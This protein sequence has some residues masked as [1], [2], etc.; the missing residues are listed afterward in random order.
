MS[1]ELDQWKRVAA[2]AG[3][4]V[5][6]DGGTFQNYTVSIGLKHPTGTWSSMPEDDKDAARDIF[7]AAYEKAVRE[8]LMG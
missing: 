8:R 1:E 6:N 5:A 2:A 4:I 7:R 3:R